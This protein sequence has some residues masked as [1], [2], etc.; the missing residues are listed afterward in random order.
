MVKFKLANSGLGDSPDVEVLFDASYTSDAY[1]I[2]FIQAQKRA[3][4]IGSNGD[5]V[6]LTQVTVTDGTSTSAQISKVL[7]L[8]KISS[9]Q[10]VEILLTLE[11]TKDQA[12][13]TDQEIV[14]T[15]SFNS[16]LKGNTDEDLANYSNQSKTGTIDFDKDIDVDGEP[17]T[18]GDKTPIDTGLWS[19]GARKSGD[20]QE[21]AMVAVSTL[22]ISLFLI[23][24]LVFIVLKW[25]K[26]QNEEAGDNARSNFNQQPEQQRA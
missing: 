17:D 19:W 22:F 3:Y 8:G 10:Q 24:I 25:R 13:Y 12:K 15:Y 11:S 4:E 6:T 14:F 18:D 9:L 23:G 1:S 26:S 7:N 5:S 16:R 20:H 21:G 2:S